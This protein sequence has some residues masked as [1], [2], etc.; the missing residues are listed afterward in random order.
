MRASG[1]LSWRSVWREIETRMRADLLDEL[2]PRSSAS[3]LSDITSTLTRV[4]LLEVPPPALQSQLPIA[5][6]VFT[7]CLSG[8]GRWPAVPIMHAIFMCG[9][10]VYCVVAYRRTGPAMFGNLVLAIENGFNLAYGFSLCRRRVIDRVLA[11]VFVDDKVA[12]ARHHSMLALCGWLTL[13]IALV[14]AAVPLV[15]STTRGATGAVMLLAHVGHGPGF[16]WLDLVDAIHNFLSWALIG[17]FVTLWLW[18]CN[19]FDA[20][21]RRLVARLTLEHVSSREASRE[22]FLHLE[23]MHAVSRYWAINHVI[24]FLTSTILACNLLVDVDVTERRDE[25]EWELLVG[26]A[27]TGFFFMSVWLTAAAPALVSET[28]LGCAMRRLGSLANE[29]DARS[30][31][32][33]DAPPDDGRTPRGHDTPTALMQR[34]ASSKDFVG[35]HFAGVPMTMQKAVSVGTLILLMLHYSSTIIAG[36]LSGEPACD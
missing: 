17:E 15:L 26:V 31:A 24:R 34:L 19:V 9:Y 6:R 27:V 20:G 29:P 18:T 12:R 8:A 36:F 10:P 2:S 7:T 30:D 13:L 32:R 1:A 35:L 25:L 33:P 22:L 16:H 28:F 14:Q 5:L 4:P 11:V 21:S 23:R 3:A